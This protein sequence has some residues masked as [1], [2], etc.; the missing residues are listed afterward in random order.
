MP[1]SVSDLIKLKLTPPTHEQ[2]V[3]QMKEAEATE[4]KPGE[5]V[6]QAVKDELASAQEQ[7]ESAKANAPTPEELESELDETEE[8]KNLS[9]GATAATEDS[10]IVI[11]NAI[12]SVETVDGPANFKQHLDDLDALV[13]AG[14]GISSVTLDNARIHVM[15]ISKELVSHPE[16]D[17]IMID[18]DLHNVMMFVRASRASSGESFTAKQQKKQVAESKKKAVSKIN[19]DALGAI[20]NQDKLPSPPAQKQITLNALSS[21]NIDNIV[22]KANKR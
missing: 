5:G 3:A 15:T 16:Y 10:L 6:S 11:P 19:L 1:L 18:R 17:G 9:T 12:E 21:L 8:S 20:G 22:A 2:L 7:P 14:N 13:V 4:I